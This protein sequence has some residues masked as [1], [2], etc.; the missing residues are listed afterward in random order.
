MLLLPPG[1][2]LINFYAC[3]WNKSITTFI[4]LNQTR[5]RKQNE[6]CMLNRDWLALSV[7]QLKFVV[8]TL[9]K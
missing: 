4:T 3:Y 6:N 8:S 1:G 5:N 9:K 2:N 7:I